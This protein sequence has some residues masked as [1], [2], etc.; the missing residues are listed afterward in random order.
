VNNTAKTRIPHLRSNSNTYRVPSKSKS[1][2]LSNNIEKIEGNHRNSQIPKNQK[3]M[4][5]EFT[6]NHDVC[7]LNY[8]NDMVSR[9]DNQSA[10]VLICENQKKDKENAKKSKELRSKG[11]LASS[12]PS[13]PR[14]FLRWI[15]TERI[16]VMCGKLTAFSNTDNKSEKSM[17]DNASTSNP[18]KPSSKRSPTCK[19][20]FKRIPKNT[21]L[22]ESRCHKKDPQMNDH[23][24]RGDCQIRIA[25]R[26]RILGGLTTGENGNSYYGAR[27]AD[28]VGKIGAVGISRVE[29][30]R[31]VVNSP[32][33][34]PLKMN[35]YQVRVPRQ[36]EHPPLAVG[37]YTAS[38]NSLLA[39]GMPC[40]F[41]SQHFISL[42]SSKIQGYKMNKEHEVHLKLVL[43]SLRKE[44]LYAKFSKCEFWLEEVHF[45]GHVVNHN[46]FTW[47]R[48]A[49]SMGRDWESSLTGLELRLP[50]EL[51][52]V[53]DTFH[54]SNLKKCLADAN[55]HV[56]LDEIKVDNTLC[57][58]EEPVKIMDGEIKKLKHRKIALVKVRWN[59][60]RRPEFTWEHKDQMRIK[61]PQLFLDR[62]VEPAS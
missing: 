29:V 62:V 47:T 28:G 42:I 15:P 5:F 2:Y 26:Q 19:R 18:S 40:A 32:M 46:A 35:E 51:N 58:V 9:A 39:V 34:Q 60:K 7:V 61:Y 24:L 45:L 3:H 37:T 6:T 14:T 30:V 54:V 22:Q 4:S 12:R 57:F 33:D 36:W 8:V 31:E 13:K 41:Y 53:H 55:L 21:R 43:E 25:H 56:P 27:I 49:Y 10:N 48:V 44:K 20:N 23:P 17:C 38:G 16:F 59:S 50:E 52:N 1:S 11:S